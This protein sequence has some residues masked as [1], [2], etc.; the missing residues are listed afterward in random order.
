[1]KRA[2]L[3]N[4]LKSLRQSD[5]K[6]W[7]RE[8]SLWCV[9]NAL[10]LALA[11]ALLW[12]YL[13]IKPS[14]GVF[15]PLFEQA[16]R[17]AI[18]L[19]L[20]SLAM[21]PAFV[22]LGWR[23]GVRLRKSAGLWAFAFASVHALVYLAPIDWRLA[24]PLEIISTTFIFFGV[25]GL[26]ILALLAA[27]SHRW[28]M[29]WLGS[30]WKAL[31]RWVYAAGALVTLHALWAVSFSKKPHLRGGWTVDELRLY[32]VIYIVLM[33]LRVPFIRD[34]LKRGRVRLQKAINGGVPKNKHTPLTPA[35]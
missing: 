15:S 2:A 22:V 3:F 12:P 17:W 10:V 18:R 9:F 4:R 13:S 35:P 34:A 25:A 23:G 29:R 30:R 28:A 21:T 24:N 20:F 7:L 19:L 26:T 16:G 14:E 33:L 6:Q 5:L 1:M 27:T 11:L 31:H 32:L 8:N